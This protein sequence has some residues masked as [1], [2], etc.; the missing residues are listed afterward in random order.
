LRWFSGQ[1]EKLVTD[2]I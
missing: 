2:G 1:C